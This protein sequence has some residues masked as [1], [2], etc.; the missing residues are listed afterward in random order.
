VA[1][2][3]AAL[4]SVTYT[5]IS[6]KPSTLTRSITITTS[7]GETS[8]PPV[9]RQIN[10]IS[11]NDVPSIS[12]P[13]S[14][15]V[16]EDGVLTFSGAGGNAIAVNDL[17]AGTNPVQLTLTAANGTLTLF[18]TTGL[19]FTIG[20]GTGDASMTFTGAIADINAA[21]N[22]LRY[23]PTA[24]YNGAAS[25]QINMSDLGNTGVPGPQIANRTVAVTVAAVNDAPVGS[26]GTVLATEDSA[27]VFKLSD[28][29]FADPSDV[30][31]HNLL[32]V[33][34]SMLPGAGA[35]TLNGVPVASGAFVSAADIAA[36][37]LRFTPTPDS[38]GAGYATLGFQVQDDGGTAGGGVDLDSV[39]RRLTIDVAGV[40]DAPQNTVSGPQSIDQD[41]TLLFSGS[42]GN[43]ISVSD[44]DAGSGPLQVTLSSTHGVLTLSGLT[45]LTFTVGDGRTMPA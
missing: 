28:F 29:G 45:G 24:D 8:S 30:P 37:L 7:D 1:N 2:Y 36:G 41:T 40:N 18:Q 39:V 20:D 14:Q 19:S 12:A 21:L 11:V 5:N 15:T 23:D 38:Y 35:L 44:I 42:G 33:R 31:G 16:S 6:Q 27:Y 43:G 9:V 32:A 10:V 4:R 13:A 25:V 34:I 3:Q 22:G 26:D 17:D